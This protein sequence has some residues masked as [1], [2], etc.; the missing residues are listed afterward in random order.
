[1]GDEI[2]ASGGLPRAAHAACVRD[3]PASFFRGALRLAV[4]RLMG[5]GIGLL[6]AVPLGETVVRVLHLTGEPRRYFSPGIY[7]AD[8]QLG[9]K[10]APSY[11]GVH[12]GR[13]RDSSVATNA[14][15]F[16][17]PEW[18]PAHEN[19]TLRILVL[20]DSCTFG[21]GVEEQET[22][23]AQL[24]RVLR[25][26]RYDAS[27]F[28]A[29]VPG[30]D[31]MQEAM[32][33]RRIAPVVE[34]QVVVVDWLPNDALERSQDLISSLQ[35]IDG[36]LVKDVEQYEEWRHHA[37]RTGIQSSALFR[38]LSARLKMLRSWLASDEDRVIRIDSAAMAYSLDALADIEHQARAIGARL[39]LV[40]FP[41]RE[42]VEQADRPLDHYEN[43]VAF[44][45]A[46]DIRVVDLAALWRRQ[47][48]LK[49]RYLPGDPVHLAPA[50]YAEI[51]REALP[52]IVGS[53]AIVGEDVHP[54]GR[55][56][57]HAP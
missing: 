44:A 5:L 1:M 41:R 21:L 39:V 25:R 43:L 50:T 12:R 36:Y 37:E 30:Y 24:E 22:F 51:A 23:P 32:L 15:G 31:T 13:D 27:V 57:D 14:L 28:N 10:L 46:H 33:L 19:S 20:G 18:N 45:R 29:G 34:P 16:R 8:S 55:R 54:L 26:E 40:L 52:A 6:A 38:L 49:A 4:L 47:D 48:P 35:V 11:R 42:E 56:M 9:W 2:E 53:H 3:R 17:G 7:A